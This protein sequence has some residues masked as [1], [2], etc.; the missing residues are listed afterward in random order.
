MTPKQRLFIKEYLIDVNATQAAIR[1]GYSRKTARQQGQRLLTNVDIFSEI[2]AAKKKREEETDI[3]AEMV[4]RDIALIAFSD[5]RDYV[6]IQGDGS[7]RAKTWDE[8]PEGA[9]RAVKEVK[10]IRRIMGRGEDG[11]EIV[12][13]C[14]LGY[15][16]HDKLKALEL[17]GNHLGMWKDRSEVLFPDVETF[18]LPKLAIAGSNGG[19]G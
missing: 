18:E 15:K 12:F 10:E 17:L 19:R 16:L 14:R 8:M 6:E 3:T 2:R 1:A 11:K 9:S 5:I 7:V 13:E 4:L